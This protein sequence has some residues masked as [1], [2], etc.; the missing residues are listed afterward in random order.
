MRNRNKR[1]SL[2]LDEKEMDNFK[3]KVNSTGLTCNSY[4]RMLLSGYGPV[5]SPDD[6]FWDSM[7]EINELADKID[8]LALKAGNPEDAIAI[9]KEANRWRAFRNEIEMSFLRPKKI[10][11]LKIVKDTANSSK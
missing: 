10:D 2:Y 4:I 9:M 8:A 3:R 11:T 7:E 6:K 5:E 1:L